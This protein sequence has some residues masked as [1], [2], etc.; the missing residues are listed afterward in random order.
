VAGVEY[1]ESRLMWELRQYR[2][3]ENSPPDTPIKELDDVT[4]CARYVEL[5]RPFS[6]VMVDR[7]AQEERAK[8]DNTSRHASEEFDELV[9]KGQRPKERRVFW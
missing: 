1:Y 5:V 9:K 4:D 3:K 2:Q 6:P 7:S 8:L